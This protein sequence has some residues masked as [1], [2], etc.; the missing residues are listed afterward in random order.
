MMPCP[1]AES[2]EG[3][4]GVCEYPAKVGASRKLRASGGRMTAVRLKTAAI[5]AALATAAITSLSL[6]GGAQSGI[7]GVL[8]EL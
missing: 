7:P 3:K 5:Q 4:C 8:S 2:I 6:S 1:R